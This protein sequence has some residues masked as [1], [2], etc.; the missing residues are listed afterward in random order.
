[1]NMHKYFL[2]GIS[3]SF[4]V[5]FSCQ[6]PEK[7][8]EVKV[9]KALEPVVLI[10]TDLG[11]IKVKLYNE[12]PVHRDNFLKLAKEGFYDDIAFHRVIK[13]FMIQAGDPDTKK[14][15]E[16][17]KMYGAADSGYKL[18]AEFNSKLFHKKGALAAAREGD[19]EN[20]EKMSSG[21]QFYLVQGKV[22][23]QKEL[24]E[25]AKR[26]N[27]YLKKFTLN[28][29]IM[30][31]AD[32]LMDKGLE[33][34]YNKIAASLQDTLMEVLSKL[35]PYSFPPEKVD[36]YS[37]VGGTPHLDGDYTVF[38]EVIEGLEVVDKIAAVETNQADMPLKPIKIS[39]KVLTE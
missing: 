33:P 28:N 23:T 14:P 1:M 15:L 13:D 8:E 21:S 3:F 11:D 34:D 5:L 31:K 18:P 24:A 4:L 16:D 39:M 7:K 9:E 10:K 20:P 19:K 35:E 12:T 36:Y 38:G 26:K 22:F 37:S 29:L 32:K 17:G 25:L 2:A 27:D 30:E 6:T